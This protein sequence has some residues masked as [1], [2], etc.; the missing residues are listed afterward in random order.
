MR[1]TK[2]DKE[3]G[4]FVRQLDYDV[5]AGLYSEGKSYSEISH[6]MGCSSTAIAYALKSMGIETRGN[7]KRKNAKRNKKTK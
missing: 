5:I 3:K 4:T 7:K 1:K 2:H 6:I